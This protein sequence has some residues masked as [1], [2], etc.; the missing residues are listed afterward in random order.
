M[1]QSRYLLKCN[2]YFELCMISYGSSA[3]LSC[4]VG[5][6]ASSAPDESLRKN[7]GMDIGTTV[8]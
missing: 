5:V 4:F 6:I 8:A 2:V 3:Q 7:G 1:V